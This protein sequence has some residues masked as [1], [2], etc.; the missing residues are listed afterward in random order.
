MMISEEEIGK[1]KELINGG[2]DLELISFEL[3]IPIE[4]LMKYK[5]DLT[6]TAIQE[7]TQ[8]MRGLSVKEKRE[9][10]K[11]ILEEIEKIE[12]CQLTIEQVER[13]NN[14]INSKE[15]NNLKSYKSDKIDLY[16]DKV[17]KNIEKKMAKTIDSN[18]S[19]IE[20]I[21]QL[22]K[23]YIKLSNPKSV[24]NSMT[25]GAVSRRIHDKILNIQQQVTMN[26]I[27]ND[28]PINII[29]IIKSLADGTL[30]VQEANKIIKEEAIK[31]VNNKPK[32]KFSLTEEQEKTKILIQIRKILAEKGEEYPIK[33]PETAVLKMQELSGGE[34]GLSIKTV[35]GNLTNRKEFEEAKRL[36]DKFSDF[37]YKENVTYGY[38]KGLRKEIRNTELG[39][40]VLKGINMYGSIEKDTEYF[41]LIK[42]GIELNNIKLS[43]ISLGKSND[44]LRNIT[45]AD[46]WP[47][48]NQKAK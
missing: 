6:I 36:C 9:K 7:K 35:V 11:V 46:I 3:E 24:K 15:L 25:C 17:R 29:E 22:K 30:D 45:L 5:V 40:M 13:I 19:E 10:V 28:I 47:D 23:L 1:I 26:K 4:Q 41:E 8:E 2:F 27:R 48:E 34:L 43:E 18:L 20:D 33:D 14:L 21:E 37:K 42:K 44:G 39:D 16:V 12:N 38:I 32:T 31:N